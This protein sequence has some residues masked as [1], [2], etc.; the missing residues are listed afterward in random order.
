MSR[1][2]LL[3]QSLF[4]YFVRLNALVGASAWLWFLFFVGGHSRFDL[5]HCF[6]AP[7]QVVCRRDW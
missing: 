7:S 5:I 4:S 3:T 1:S 6:D 2:E